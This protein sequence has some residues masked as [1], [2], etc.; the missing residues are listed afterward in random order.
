VTGRS[1]AGRVL[2]RSV[3]NPPRV[4]ATFPHAPFPDNHSDGIDPDFGRIVSERA[5]IEMERN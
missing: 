4:R 5:R 3:P 2:F 1:D